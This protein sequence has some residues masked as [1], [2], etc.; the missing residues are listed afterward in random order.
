MPVAEDKQRAREQWSQDPA[1]AIYGREH[2][3]GTREFFDA[4]ERHRYTEYAPWM[5]EVMGFKEFGD[6]RLLEVGCGMGTD[7]LQFARGGAKVTGID[8]TPRS[9][10]IS[11][12]HFEVYGQRGDFAISD[13]EKLPFK[14]ESFDVVY[15]H[16]VL[17]HTPD[18]AGAVRELH[19]VLRRGGQARVML[20]HR[21]SAA[22]WLQIILRH[23]LLRGEL[24]R[25]R[26]PEQI[27]SRYVE[28]NEGGGCPLVKVYSRTQA[29]KLFSMFRDV[30]VEV[31]QLT[32]AELSILG[33]LIPEG[34][35]RFLRQ[36]IGGNVII[37]ARK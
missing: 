24:L 11:R 14:S 7:L 25:G 33:R 21:G 4:V 12:R 34:M 22:Y 19:R 5:P 16:G 17:H 8:L 37:S 6:A 9:I 20:Y 35:F 32:R 31:E 26:S 30:S 18:T 27:M 29:R 28:V 1:G 3:F 13:C 36:T 23:G 2:E 15:S 10:E